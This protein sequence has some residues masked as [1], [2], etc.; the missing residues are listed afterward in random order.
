[1]PKVRAF[2]NSSLAAEVVTSLEALGQ[3]IAVTRKARGMSQKEM[4]ATVG[5]SPQTML[6]I[7]QGRPNVQI[8]HYA[9]ALSVLG[10]QTLGL[11]TQTQTAVY[12]KA[13]PSASA[14]ANAVQRHLADAQQSHAPYI[15][16][17]E[18]AYDWSNPNIA[19]ATLI[20][21]VVEKGRFHDLAIICKRFGLEQVRRIA[22]EKIA[23]SVTLRRAFANIEQGFGR[24][25]LTLLGQ[26]VRSRDLY[27][28]FILAKEHGYTIAQ[29]LHD[30]ATYGTNDDPEY[31]KAVLRGEIPLDIDD[32][33]LE[34]VGVATD[35]NVIYS[36]FDTQIS[37]IEI[38]EA[39]RIARESD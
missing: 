11:Q 5:I 33:G 7:E 30:A 32:E 24:T 1:M 3:K 38:D 29:L 23:N 12:D 9:R 28:L 4:A 15:N 14:R 10:S 22:S 2:Q 34:P 18:F 35:L 16:G 8:G 17:L 13:A 20:R 19:D 31:Y 26:R 39:A 36:F 25:N 21:K 27:D 6:F 37:L